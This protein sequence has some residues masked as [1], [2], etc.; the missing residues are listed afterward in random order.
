MTEQMKRDFC[1]LM[2]QK[3]GVQIDIHNELL[4]VFYTAYQSAVI[5]EKTSKKSSQEILSIISKF[6][7]E[8]S[9]RLKK[10]ATRQF[11]FQSSKE[12]FWFAFGSYGL[13][14]LVAILGI[15]VLFY[16]WRL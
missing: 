3:F 9:A 5:S 6:D 8:T 7:K 15:L 12:A 4:P 2:L 16:V 14:L 10:L 11:H 13:P 1:A